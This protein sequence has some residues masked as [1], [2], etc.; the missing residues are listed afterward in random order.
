MSDGTGTASR[1]RTLTPDEAARRVAMAR[2]AVVGE[3][4]KMI[5]GHEDLIEFLLIA[6]FS[7]GHVL[8]GGHSGSARTSLLSTF[9]KALNLK[10]RH[11]IMSEDS[12]PEDVSGYEKGAGESDSAAR[13]I[14]RGPIFSELLVADGFDQSSRRTQAELFHALRHSRVVIAG[15]TYELE[16]PRLVCATHDANSAAAINTPTEKQLD[17]FMFS[18]ELGYPSEEE[19]RAMVAR[20]VAASQSDVRVVLRPR[21]IL[22]VQ[23]LAQQMPVLEQTVGYAVDLVRATRPEGEG[24]PEFVKSWIDFGAGPRASQQLVVAAKAR[25]LIKGRSLVHSA[26]IRAVARPVLRHRI[27]LSRDAERRGITVQ[28]VVGKIVAV[29][30]ERWVGTER[31]AN[32]VVVSDPAPQAVASGPRPT[33]TA[34]PMPTVLPNH[35]F[36]IPQPPATSAWQATAAAESGPIGGGA[37]ADQSHWPPG[38]SP[39]ERGSS[40][41]QNS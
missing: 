22:W 36:L 7:R 11:F 19:E 14:V 4:Q 38:E 10:F 35:P 29:V 31:P 1:E 18:F 30:K 26:D 40:D 25:A 27:F 2:D 8:I 23:Q 34:H 12:S 5:V 24:V 33:A 15:K 16:Q 17:Q 37:P 21:D 20:R 6:L 41:E 28:Q 39:N 3:V 13:R 32:L 9:A